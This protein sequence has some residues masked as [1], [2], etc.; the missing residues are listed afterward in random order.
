MRLEGIFLDKREDAVPVMQING[1][2]PL[3]EM[4]SRLS[5][6]DPRVII[7]E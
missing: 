6:R 4:V 3:A 1:R 5:N 2:E 7:I